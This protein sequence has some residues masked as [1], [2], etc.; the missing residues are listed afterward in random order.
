MIRFLIRS[1]FFG[2]LAYVVYKILRDWGVVKSDKG[3]EVKG[4]SQSQSLDLKDEDVQDVHF[5]DI[6]DGKKR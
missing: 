6:D 1:L 3:G 2:L 4:K 5:E